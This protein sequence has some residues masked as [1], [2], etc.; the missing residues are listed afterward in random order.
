MQQNNRV[1]DQGEG[2]KAQR[3]AQ[4]ARASGVEGAVGEQCCCQLGTKHGEEDDH[5]DHRQQGDLG[6]LG[7]VVD[8]GA[9]VAIGCV[10]R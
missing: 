2:R 10:T 3:Q 5:R 1:R 9:V 4:D 6:G 8:D 7:E